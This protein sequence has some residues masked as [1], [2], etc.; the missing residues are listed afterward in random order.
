MSTKE[1]QAER[2]AQ[3]A[4][5]GSA[6]DDK[7]TLAEWAAL[8]SHYATRHAVGDLHAIDAAAF[9]AD[10]VKVGALALACIE[11]IDRKVP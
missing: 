7:W 9:R 4:K 10:V 5:W 11:A 3:H 1:I 2:D 6:D 8:L